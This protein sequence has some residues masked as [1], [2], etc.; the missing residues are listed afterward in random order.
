MTTSTSAPPSVEELMP[1]AIELA[2]RTGRVPSRDRLMKTFRIGRPKADQIF[3][4]LQMESAKLRSRRA[5]RLAEMQQK[6]PVRRTREVRLFDPSDMP[7]SPG[8]GPV[9][10]WAYAVPASPAVGQ[11]T[12]SEGSLP[13]AGDAP[14]PAQ[15]K[16]KKRAATWPVILLALPAFVAIWSGWVD[17][18]RLTGFGVVHPLPG[19]ADRVA[20][21]TAITLPVGLETYAAYALYVWLSGTVPAIAARFARRSAIGSLALGAGGQVAYHLMVAAGMQRAPWWITT[22]VACLPV[23][24]LGMGAALRHL[25]HAEE[26]AGI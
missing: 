20:L 22:L 3:R 11:Q 21:N 23:A 18:G 15:V 13:D 19:I 9:D 12:A 6:A 4:R 5:R 1:Q 7:V 8:V 14:L 26:A 25:V 24:V 2:G 17:L 10:P 16:V